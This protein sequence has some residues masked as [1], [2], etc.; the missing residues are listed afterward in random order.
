MDELVKKNAKKIDENTAIPKITEDNIFELFQ[1]QTVADLRLM[2]RNFM[3]LSLFLDD[4]YGKFENKYV[5]NTD[6]AT[7]EKHGIAKLYSE[8]EAETTGDEVKKIV[9]VGN[10]DQQ[11]YVGETPTGKT[12]W[13]KLIDKLDH[14]KIL[15]V[16]GLIK[17]L[18]KIIKPAGESTY[19]LTTNA[20]IKSL[21]TTHA[22]KPDLSP[23]VTYT[24]GFRNTNNTDAFVRTNGVLTWASFVIEMWEGGTYRGKFHTNGGRAYYAVPGRNGGNFNEIMDN[25]DMAVRD[26][27]LNGLD[28]NI[29]DVRRLLQD[30]IIWHVRDMRLAGYILEQ[31]PYERNGYVVTMSNDLGNNTVQYARRALQFYRNGQWLNV[32]FA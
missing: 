18:R 19:G 3:R 13:S 20:N 21:I 27:R 15:T 17:I 25:H 32:P 1:L 31:G 28:I 2:S 12:F 5:K 8:V 23:Y 11:E 24:K 26:N 6:Y 4:I 7:E 22:P 14:T 29:A 9:E 16:K 10:G 30:V